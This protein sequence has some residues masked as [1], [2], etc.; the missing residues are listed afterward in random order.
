MKKKISTM[1]L[2]VL[3]AMT[4]TM[5]GNLAFAIVIG[6]TDGVAATGSIVEDI[7]PGPILDNFNDD[8]HS[9]LWAGVQD[10][11]RVLEVT[12]LFRTIQLRL[13]KERIV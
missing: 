5:L 1:L 4:V 8:G 6:D 10:S 9:N 11:S 7:M 2:A 12:L 3:V 13:K